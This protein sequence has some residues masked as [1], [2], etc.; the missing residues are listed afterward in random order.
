MLHTVLTTRGLFHIAGNFA[1]VR[2]YQSAVNAGQELRFDAK[3]SAHD[4]AQL[5][6]QFLKALPEPI[7]TFALY[8]QVLEARAGTSSLVISLK[9]HFTHRPSLRASASTCA[10]VVACFVL[11]LCLCFLCSGL[12]MCVRVLWRVWC[13]PIHAAL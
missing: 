8:E 7:V 9:C 11:A 5:L 2:E 10:C 1:R 13:A 6:K 3:T 12:F 4:V